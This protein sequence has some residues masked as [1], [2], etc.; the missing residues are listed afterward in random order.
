MPL[1]RAYIGK[2]GLNCNNEFSLCYVA[3][4]ISGKQS[5]VFVERE[6]MFFYARTLCPR[7]SD[8]LNPFAGI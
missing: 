6:I 3:G 2:V 8:I 4:G 7:S 5:S 1:N